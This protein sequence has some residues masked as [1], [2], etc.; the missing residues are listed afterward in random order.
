MARTDQSTPNL[1]VEEGIEKTMRVAAVV[2]TSPIDRVYSFAIPEPLTDDI[3]AGQRVRV[4]FGKGNR[5]VDGFV[6]DVSECKWNSTLKFI[7]SIVDHKSWLSGHLLE[8]GKWLS[9]YYCTPAGRTLSVMVPAVVRKQSGYRRVRYVALS[10]ALEDIVA[11]SPRIGPKQRQLLE[12]LSARGGSVEA[13]S[14][15]EQAGVSTATLRQAVKRGWVSERIEKQPAAAPDFDQPIEEPDFSLNDEQ[16]QAC[17]QVGGYI[18]RREFKVLLL[19]G[20]SGS[21]KTEVYIDALKRA[22]SQGRQAIVLVPEIA[23]TTQLVHRF[24]SRLSDVAVIHSGL[25]GTQRSLTWN[26][27]H[28]GDKRVVIGA[29]SAVFAPCKDLGL[30]VVDEEQEQSYKNQQ[31]PRFHARDAA[32]KRAQ[33]LGIPILLGSATPSLETWHNCNTQDHYRTLHLTRRVAGLDMPKVEMVDMRDEEKSRHGFHLLSRLLEKR[34]EDTL[35]RREQAVLLLNRRGYSHA[36]FC[37]SCKSRVLCHNCH[38]SMVFHR[39]TGEAVC[40]HCYSKMPAPQHCADPSCG[41]RLLRFGVGTERV[42]EEIRRK[43]PDARV[44]RVDSDTM[45]N[46]RDYENVVAA[47]EAREFDIM[48]GT[49][50]VAKGLDFPF[51]SLVGVVSADTALFLPD[52]RANESTFQLV[53]QVAGRAGRAKTGGRVVVQTLMGD[54]PVLQAAQ[55]HD[56]DAFA[57][58]ELKV[59]RETH[60]PPFTRLTRWILSDVSESILKHAAAKFAETI[61]EAC[62]HLGLRSAKVSGPF[63]SPLERMRKRYRYDVLLRNSN[64]QERRELLD[65]LKHNKKLNAKV[66][67]VVI[68]VDPVSFM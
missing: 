12:A 19:Y 2:P 47:F 38:A 43:F 21:G 8:L 11:S 57:E 63:P 45:G 50:M 32:I 23:L 35:A 15:C 64:A 40:H 31:A 48:V 30:I 25:T 17:D 3:S 39:T 65:Y 14:V 52:F 62:S 22:V 26:A 49:Q 34:L 56:Y 61:R 10:S 28:N 33:L 66:Q 6:L 37:P 13:A 7:D 27:I 41:T 60:M 44:R 1:W 24:A 53:T 9:D 68:D 36:L 29:R 20:V 59:R 16:R 58:H 51:V 46:V 54:L 4:P 5:L 67:R 42:E 55:K 18:D